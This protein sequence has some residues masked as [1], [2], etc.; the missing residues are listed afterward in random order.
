MRLENI[1]SNQILNEEVEVV[2]TNADGKKETFKLDDTY[3]KVISRQLRVNQNSGLGDNIDSMF[4]Q[5][6]WT[7]PK[8]GGAKNKYKEI[9][10][11]SQYDEGVDL[12]EH[13][14]T[15]KNT[16]LKLSDYLVLHKRVVV[17]TFN[18]MVVK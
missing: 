3:G 8:Q 2:I 6:D 4:N 5:A 13:L 9:V 1:Y 18:G 14:A 17:V 15:K 12:T 16:L 7:G 10:I 11:N